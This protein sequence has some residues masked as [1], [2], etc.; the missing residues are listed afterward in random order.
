[1]EAL[2]ILLAVGVFYFT[3]N[4]MSKKDEGDSDLQRIRKL[5]DDVT[6]ESPYKVEPLVATKRK[7]R[8]SVKRARVLPKKTKKV[9]KP[10]KVV[11][12]KVVAKK[13]PKKAVKKK[14]VKKK[15]KTKRKTK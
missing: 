4:S 2:I 14:T 7:T 1:M 6:T 12:K 13:L 15:V 5:L 3:Y 11:K 10:K 8:K 9:V